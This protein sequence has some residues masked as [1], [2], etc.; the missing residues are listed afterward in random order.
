MSAPIGPALTALA[1]GQLYDL[2]DGEEIRLL[3]FD[4]GL[5][6]VR[7]LSQRSPLQQGDTDL[8]YRVDPRY[9]D[10]VWAIKGNSLP[11][12]RDVRARILEVW[13]PRDDA[14]QVVFTF[15]DRVRALD[16]HLDGELN[17]FERSGVIEKVSGVFKASDPR[18]YDPSI[19]TALFSLSSSIGG[20]SGWPIPW[21]IPWPIGSDVLDLAFSIDYAG[22]SRLAAPE[23]P[24]IRV[25]GPISNPVIMNE[26]T[27][28]QIDL[29][30][31]GGLILADPTKWVDID[32]AGPARRDAKTIRDQDGNS[33]DQYLT[34]DSDFATWHL[35]PAGEL[36]YDGSYATGTNVI[37]VTG[38]GVTSNTL[39][40]M[41]YY[42]R[43]NGV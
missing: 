2:N 13:T 34:T 35:A 10:L 38:S 29:S 24:I 28:E 19:H 22:S 14:V 26:T 33:A 32:L 7:R 8:G 6:S 41:N 23:Y 18:L 15:E 37:R 31:N 39:V 30:A 4:L 11:H 36:L 40:T 43:Y 5:A 21:P 3:D 12:Y 17:W 42:D 9:V 20:G 1:A 27:N 25:R 16:L